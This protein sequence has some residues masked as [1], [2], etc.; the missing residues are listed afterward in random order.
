[1]SVS[2]SCFDPSV[3]YKSIDSGTK[4]VSK[5]YRLLTKSVVKSFGR[6]SDSCRHERKRSARA[7]ISGTC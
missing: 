1:M 5:E 3:L 2:G 7:V 6:S 4:S